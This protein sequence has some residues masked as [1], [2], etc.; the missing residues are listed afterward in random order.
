MLL[1][2][3][4]QEGGRHHRGRSG[5]QNPLPKVEAAESVAMRVLEFPGRETAFGSDGED[6]AAGRSRA[7]SPLRDRPCRSR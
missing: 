1:R 7:G 3:P 2:L 4:E 6:A 5:P